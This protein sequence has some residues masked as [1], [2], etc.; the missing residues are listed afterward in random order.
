ML[1]ILAMEEHAYTVNEILDKFVA[2][3][4]PTLGERTQKDYAYHVR[5]L[6]QWFGHRIANEIKPKDFREFMDIRGRGK[7]QRNRQLAVL[8]CAFSEAVKTNEE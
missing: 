5:T 8:S 3:Y 1:H 4:V 6:R 2:D 7:I